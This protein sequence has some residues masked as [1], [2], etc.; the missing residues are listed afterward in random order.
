MKYPN[1]QR[2][3]SG[4]VDVFPD[5]VVL[6]CDTSSG[7]VTINLAEIPY[8]TTTGQGFW[9]TQYRLYINDVSNNAGTNNITVVAGTGQTINNQPT[10]V[11]NTNG[12]SCYIMISGNTEYSLFFAPAQSSPSNFITV[13]YAQLTALVNANQIIP[14]ADYLLLDAEFGS[15]PFMTPT[16]IFLKGMTINK[17]TVIYTD[18]IFYNADYDNVGNY[19]SITG[20]AGQLGIWTSALVTPL[21]SVVIWDNT[22][23]VNTSGVNGVTNPTTDVANWSALTPSTTNGYI[24]VIDTVYYRYSSN[25]IIGRIDLAGNEVERAIRSGVN[26]LN[27]FGWGNSKLKQNK[28]VANSV[29]NCCNTR[30]QN[31]CFHNKLSGS[32]L[33][34]S[35]TNFAPTIENCMGNILE[36]SIVGLQVGAT[37]FDK[38]II[39]SST[40]GF[41]GNS[42]DQFNNNT[43]QTSTLNINSNNGTIS[44]NQIVNSIFNVTV[45]NAGNI[46]DNIIDNSTFSIESNTSPIALISQNNLYQGAFMTIKENLGT[47][48][49]NTVQ[50]D[51]NFNITTINAFG[52]IIQFVTLLDRSLFTIDTNNGSCGVKGGVVIDNVSNLGI[53]TLNSLIGNISILETSSLNIVTCDDSIE[54]LSIEGD[55]SLA[56]RNILFGSNGLTNLTLKSVGSVGGATFDLLATTGGLSGNATNGFSTVRTSL[57][58]S[59]LAIYNAGTQTLTIDSNIKNIVGVFELQNAG[60]IT[61]ANIVGLSDKW[62]T[63][64]LPDAGTTTFQSVAVGASSPPDIVSDSGAFAFNITRHNPNLSDSIFLTDSGGYA[65]VRDTN[66]LV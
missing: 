4:I 54:V 26:S 52:S 56:I 27:V 13:T 24:Q 50:Q 58:C 30:F 15:A 66:I 3:V 16:N 35:Q 33:D 17:T 51:S 61:I 64:F 12:T 46:I 10:L 1:T 45:V 14:N 47:I 42:S 62:V 31:D 23:Y 7:A 48:Q 25:L 60:G 41:T 2:T 55:T 38:N 65:V 39:Y 36:F 44:N 5:D 43:I 19:S 8:N 40:L 49:K 53:N 11:L 20:F 32:F 29:F 37:K 22:H 18:G 57:D 9:S 28:I 21:N 59:D 34:F 63:Q 6:N